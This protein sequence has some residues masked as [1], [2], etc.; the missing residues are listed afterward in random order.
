MRALLNKLDT[1]HFIILTTTKPCFL[2]QYL[3]GNLFKFKLNFL[4]SFVISGGASSPYLSDWCQNSTSICFQFS[5]PMVQ[6]RHVYW[7]KTGRVEKW[8]KIKLLLRCQ[9][10]C[11]LVQMATGTIC[12]SSLQLMPM[13][14]TAVLIQENQWMAM[15]LLYK[16]GN[17]FGSWLEQKDFPPPRFVFEWQELQRG[18]ELEM[19]F[20]SS[21]PNSPLEQ[22]VTLEETK[23]SLTGFTALFNY[24]S[25]TS[26]LDSVCCG[27]ITAREPDRLEVG[28][29]GHWGSTKGEGC[30][31][32]GNMWLRWRTISFEGTSEVQQSQRGTEQKVKSTWT[33]LWIK[34]FNS[35][36]HAHTWCNSNWYVANIS[37]CRR[38]VEPR[39]CRT[40]GCGIVDAVKSG[41]ESKSLQSGQNHGVASNVLF[42]VVLFWFSQRS[43][44]QNMMC[45]WD[46][47]QTNWGNPNLICIPWSNPFVQF[48]SLFNTWPTVYGWAWAGSFMNEIT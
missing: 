18:L 33:R 27:Q 3:N 47:C 21:G 23:K 11:R 16:S 26:Q 45:R 14:S 39:R 40:Y 8:L 35:T 41:H 4:V 9:L 6:A 13:T 28:R 19:K 25:I 2:R 10:F 36:F 20:L 37:V 5:L 44:L 46:N 29:C 15:F 43:S 12:W 7:W 42:A 1:I 34:S 22:P 31:E 17:S 32:E 24:A 48:C 38:E 30:V